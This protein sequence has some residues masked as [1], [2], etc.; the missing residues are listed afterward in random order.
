[1][2]VHHPLR[3]ASRTVTPP[4]SGVANAVGAAA[5]QVGAEIDRVVKIPPGS[6][7][8][9]MRGL[10]DAAIA[11]AYEA[12]AL[13]GSVDILHVDEIPIPYAADGARRVLIKAVGELDAMRFRRLRGAVREGVGT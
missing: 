8:A 5:A 9:V 11:A 13:T 10:Q 1:M 6:R 7:D 3:G 2:L 4:H 12:G